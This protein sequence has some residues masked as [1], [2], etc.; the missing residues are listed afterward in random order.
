[1]LSPAITDGIEKTAWKDSALLNVNDS[2]SLLR[3]S[4]RCQQLKST[5]SSPGLILLL[6]QVQEEA[7][8]VRFIGEHVQSAAAEAPKE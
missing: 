8:E 1:M 5:A 3:I 6:P 4:M 2:V 7:T